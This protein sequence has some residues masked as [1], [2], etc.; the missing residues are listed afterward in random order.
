MRVNTL[1]G[2]GALIKFQR[3]REEKKKIMQYIQN[4]IYI[5]M[6]FELSCGCLPVKKI[7]HNFVSVAICNLL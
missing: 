2:Q 7:V 3:N 6:K 1:V 4:Y 5:V